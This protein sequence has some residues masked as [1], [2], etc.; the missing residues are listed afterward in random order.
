[1]AADIPLHKLEHPSIHHLF[2]SIGKSCPSE[3]SSRQ[4]VPQLFSELQA[5]IVEYVAHKKTF[6]IVDVSDV[7]GSKFFN[8]LVGDLDDPSSVSVGL[9]SV[10]W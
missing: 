8:I 7:S 3:T 6:I 9:H 2:K 5:R 10:G 4:Y 1:M